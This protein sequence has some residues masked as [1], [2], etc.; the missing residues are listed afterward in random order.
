MIR[1]GVPPY[2][3]VS[4]RG[5]KRFSALYAR[6]ATLM[7]STIEELYQGS[8]EFEPYAHGSDANGRVTNW[9]DA[10]GKRPKNT[11]F[12]AWYYDTLW[13]QYLL[14]NS[15][16]LPTL[17]E[18]TGLSDRFGQ[19]GSNCQATTLWLLREE[20]IRTGRIAMPPRPV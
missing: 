16:L 7:F 10:K 6:I 18:A 13:R 14:E 4:S 15:F 11:V 20:Y 19:T 12:V 3:E 8:K 2:L 17:V 9:R 5:D 1:H